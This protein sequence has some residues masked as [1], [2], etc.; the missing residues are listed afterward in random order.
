MLAFARFGGSE[1]LDEGLP[2]RQLQ[3]MQRE[4]TARVVTVSGL[5]NMMS[6]PVPRGCPLTG[7]G[8]DRCDGRSP[9]PVLGI[10]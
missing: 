4:V 9:F 1:R 7:I 5:V 3:F 2:K 10:D 8:G 6:A